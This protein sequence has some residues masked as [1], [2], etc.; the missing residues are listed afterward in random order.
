MDQSI[1]RVITRADRYYLMETGRF[2]R[3]GPAVAAE[4]DAINAIVL[5][6]VPDVFGSGVVESSTKMSQAEG[7]EQAGSA[8]RQKNINAPGSYRYPTVN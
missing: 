7:P 1:E 3:S 6:R 8:Q 2:E 5:A 4:V